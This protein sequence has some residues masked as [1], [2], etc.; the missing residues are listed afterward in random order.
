MPLRLPIAFTTFLLRLLT[1]IFA[2][3]IALSSNAQL[4][5]GSL[6]DA[7]VNITFGTGANGNT[8]GYTP[9]SAYTYTS[10]SCPNDGFYTITNYTS[11][12]FSNSWLTVNSDHTGNGA[13]LLVN[14]SYAPGDFFVNTVSDLCPNTTYEFAAWIINVLARSGIK[15]NITFSIETPTG[16]VLQQ[17]STGDIPETAVATWKQYGFYFTTP[18]NNPVIVLRMTNNAPGGGGNDLGL[19]DITFRPCSASKITAAIQGNADTLQLCQNNTNT[20]TLNGSVSAGYVAPVYN[21]QLSTDSGKIWKDIPSANGLNYL[22]TPTAA[23]AYWYRLSVIEQSAAAY[24]SCRIASNIVVINV[25]AKPLVNA[26]ADKVVIAGDTVT[27]DASVTGENPVYVWDPPTY[28]N[29]SSVLNPTTLPLTDIN[30]TLYVTTAFG[31]KNQDD[32]FVKVVAGIFVPNAFTPNKDGKNDSWSIPYLD[33]QFNA[34][35]NVYNRF[36]QLV[37]H[38]QGQPVNWDGNFKDLPQAAGAYVYS[39]T[40]KNGRKAMKGTFL[41]IR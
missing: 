34:T 8:G 36:G 4:C 3:L 17:Y 6:G 40:F 14:A 31:C 24:T 38:V 32:V 13:F 11:G 35:V 29:N 5:N 28:L 18:I 9:T 37:Y 16:V 10:S 20:F 23:G 2:L 33:P 12:C 41:L 19:D 25:Y 15:P 22:R 30:Y 1:T 7:A 26:G 21:W 39:I 27:L